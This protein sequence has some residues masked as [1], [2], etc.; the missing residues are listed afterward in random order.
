MKKF[1]E[2][3]IP[4]YAV[5]PLLA[6]MILNTIVYYGNRLIPKYQ[7]FDVSIPAIDDNIPLVTW[8]IV[9][10]VFSYV[11]WVVGFIIIGRESKEVCYEMLSGEM[12]AKSMCLVFFFAIP[13]E[14]VDWPSGQFE[15]NNVFDWTTQLIY[16]MDEPNNLFPSIHCLESWVV[17]RGAF[18]CKKVR[19]WYRIYCLVIMLGIFASTVLVRQHVVVDILGG[20]LVAELGLVL[21]K[22][23]RLGRIFSFLDRRKGVA[24]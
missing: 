15:I 19:P 21:A 10:Y 22:R 6:C 23:F 8:M 16:D 11:F 17:T 13:T 20:I 4:R 3:L 2:K 12:V 5:I 1:I 9:F 7:F 18:R 24:V 14:M